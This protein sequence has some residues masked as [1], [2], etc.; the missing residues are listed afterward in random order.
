MR[1]MVWNVQKSGLEKISGLCSCVWV[2]VCVRARARQT[3]R[4]TNGVCNPK[5]DLGI[6]LKFSVLKNLLLLFHEDE[7]Y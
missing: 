2:G 6:G 7:L 5:I 1:T 4:N 3:S